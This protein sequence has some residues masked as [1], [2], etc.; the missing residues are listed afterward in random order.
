MIDRVE[1]LPR[2]EP[3]V[4]NLLAVLRRERTDRVPLF[5][6]KLDEEVAASL[7]G[8]P[9]VL[10]QRD[11][12]PDERRQAIR[13]GVGLARRLGY[14]TLRVRADIPF[15]IIKDPATDTAVLTRG[16]RE[17]QNEHTG[18]IQ[19][20]KDLERYR[21]PALA[22]VDLGP[23]EEIG[24]ELPDGMACV[25]FCGGVFEWSSWLMGLE[26]FSIALY[27]EPALVREVVDRVGRLVHEVFEAWATMDHVAALWCGDDMGF[28]TATLVSPDHLREYILPWHRRYAELAHAHG[29][30]YILHSCGNLRAIMP[31]LADD[32]RIDAR[33]SFE[34]VIEPVEECFHQWGDKVAMLG[35]VDVDLLSRGTEADVERRTLQI[36][37]ACAP[38]GGYVAGS[39]N[40]VTNYIP[41]ENYLAMVETVHRFNGRL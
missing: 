4:D 7:M 38:S 1:R 11:A 12:P 40:S 29:R 26:S 35:G 27:D 32:V 16:Q 34:D 41:V 5:E 15:D 19:S 28:K 14:D 22:N 18:P 10:W 20:F 9:V 3:N 13:Q 2:P 30:P 37:E 21:W 8:E 6:L 31:D 36:L 39:G 24:R 23:G 25:G 17:W 33:H